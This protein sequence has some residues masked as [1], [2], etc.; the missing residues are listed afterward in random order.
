VGEKGSSWIL[1]STFSSDS[2][3]GLTNSLNGLLAGLELALS[4]LTKIRPV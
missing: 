4:A 1:P 3:T 2:L